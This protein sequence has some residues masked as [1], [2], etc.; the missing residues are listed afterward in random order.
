MGRKD[1]VFAIDVSCFNWIGSNIELDIAQVQNGDIFEVCQS[2][3]FCVVD[4]STK[5]YESQ[6][7]L[8]Y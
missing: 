7:M 2:M 6:Y 3:P 8:C 1:K 5:Q 4:F